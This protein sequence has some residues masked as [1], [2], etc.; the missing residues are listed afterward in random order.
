MDHEIAASVVT[1]KTLDYAALAGKHHVNY[2]PFEAEEIRHYAQQAWDGLKDYITN[3]K[4]EEPLVGWYSDTLKADGRCDL[5]SA[6]DSSAFVWDWKT[7]YSRYD[8]AA[9]VTAYAWLLKQQLKTFPSSG[10]IVGV[11][12]W[13]RRGER[14]VHHFS[15][16]QLN[17]FAESVRQKAERIGRDW[18]PGKHCA[19]C[20]HSDICDAKLQYTKSAVTELMAV[21]NGGIELDRE[22]IGG[23]F[24]ERLEAIKK[25]VK[26][27]E[28]L[29]KA[30]LAEGPLDCGDGN[31]LIE[32]RQR[33][34]K[35]KYTAALPVIKE[36]DVG[37]LDDIV[38][39]T[40]SKLL[41]AM[42]FE[43]PRGQKTA[44]RKAALDKLR[45]AGA[46]GTAYRMVQR[47][48]NKANYLKLLDTK[49]DENE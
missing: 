14:K 43:A 8:H 31:L 47:T 34:D 1:G 44:A 27:G 25:A 33:Q 11:E 13:L 38:S 7:G 3:P 26:A 21:Q 39:V 29:I 24:R 6:D 40:K 10:I 2:D 49:Q 37:G 48:V 46:V 19:F 42:T 36:Y 22:T 41:E 18:S 15:A 12:A 17:E 30:A 45:E 32:Q 20:P 28:L 16:E 9:Q 4:T 35:I 23:P 5:I